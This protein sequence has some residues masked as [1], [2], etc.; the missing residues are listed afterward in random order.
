MELKI[1]TFSAKIKIKA[2]TKVRSYKTK[3][4]FV[5]TLKTTPL[6]RNRKCTMARINVKDTN[7]RTIDVH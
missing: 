3:K 5:N 4:I 2:W 1:N 7:R 6:N